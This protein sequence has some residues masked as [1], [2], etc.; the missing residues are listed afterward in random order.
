MSSY[1]RLSDHEKRIALALHYAVPILRKSKKVKLTFISKKGGSKK[2][3]SMGDIADAIFTDRKKKRVAG[4]RVVK[5]HVSTISRFL[6][7]AKGKKKVKKK[8]GPKPF[9]HP[10]AARKIPRIIEKLEKKWPDDDVNA[11]MILEELKPRLA[12]MNASGRYPY[13]RTPKLRTLQT[14]MHKSGRKARRNLRKINLDARMKAARMAFGKKYVKK[15]IHKWKRCTLA[16]D[17]KKFHWLG[18]PSAKHTMKGRGKRFSYRTVSEGL[19]FTQPH[20][21]RH[22]TAG[23]PVNVMCVLGDGKVRAWKY[24]K[25][26]MNKALWTDMIEWDVVPAVAELPEVMRSGGRALFL[27]DAAP[28]SHAWCKDVEERWQ[29]DVVEQPTNS[30]DLNPLDFRLWRLIAIKMRRQEKRWLKKHPR[31]EWKETLSEYKVRLRKT[32][33]RLTKTEIDRAMG[34]M[35]SKC[36]ELI[37]VKGGHLPSDCGRSR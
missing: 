26:A 10:V 5:P 25:G 2:L 18:T 17:E 23:T 19:K 30:P 1:K 28:Q 27:R 24:Y 36:R 31:K 14:Y 12:R 6:S 22:W 34:Q 33:F 16:S 4:R 29:L 13:Q 3:L 20:E 37:S 21:S 35:Q 8:P 32:A 11:T 9:L 7:G 15:T